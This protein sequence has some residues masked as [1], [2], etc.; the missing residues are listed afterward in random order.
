MLLFLRNDN[1]ASRGARVAEASRIIVPD[2]KSISLRCYARTAAADVHALNSCPISPTGLVSGILASQASWKYSAVCCSTI[3][4]YSAYTIG[5]TQWRTKF[6]KQMIALENEAS[7]KVGKNGGTVGWMECGGWV[8]Q[9]HRL[10]YWS[11]GG[12]LQVFLTER[13]PVTPP[14]ECRRDAMRG[15]Y[16][17]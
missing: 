6:R 3:F 2:K 7:A 10:V 4:A 5:I 17:A 14:V 15:I 16:T 12:W 1:R 8:W 13:R 9:A 11:M